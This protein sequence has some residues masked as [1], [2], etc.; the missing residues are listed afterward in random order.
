MVRQIF[1]E[2]EGRAGEACGDVEKWEPVEAGE[3]L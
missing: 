1:L 3:T 2:R